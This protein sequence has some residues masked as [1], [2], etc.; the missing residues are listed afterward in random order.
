MPQ[1]NPQKV[2]QR[3]HAAPEETSREASQI[4]ALIPGLRQCVQLTAGNQALSSAFRRQ[5]AALQSIYTLLTGEAPV[6]SPLP[7]EGVARRAGGGVSKPASLSPVTLR[8]CY[9]QQL[10]ALSGYQTLSGNREF[11]PAF[12]ALIPLAQENCLNILALLGS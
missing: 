6:H 8:R 9:A 1:Y 5:T 3:V 7:G 10:Q 12:Q 11:G 4:L 2:W